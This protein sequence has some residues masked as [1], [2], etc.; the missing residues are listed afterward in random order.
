MLKM[1]KHSKHLTNLEQIHG[2]K[3]KPVGDADLLLDLQAALC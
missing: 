3:V 1:S 2:A